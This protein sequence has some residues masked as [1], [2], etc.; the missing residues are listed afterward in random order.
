MVVAGGAGGSIFHKPTYKCTLPT[1][2]FIQP[3]V[4]TTVC[5]GSTAQFV[6]SATN[7]S[8]VIYLVDSMTISSVASR[9][10]NVSAPAYSG[11]MA[12]RNLT[13]LGIPTNNNSLITC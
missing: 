6:C 10:I 2:T 5:L 12:V 1:A 11:N 3:L 9:R 13:I 4:N 8:N 7:V